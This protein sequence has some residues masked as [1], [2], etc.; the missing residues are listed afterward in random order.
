M[1]EVMRSLRDGRGVSEEGRFFTRPYK[2]GDFCLRIKAA[3]K[4]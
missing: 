1:L 3:V 2:M 4:H